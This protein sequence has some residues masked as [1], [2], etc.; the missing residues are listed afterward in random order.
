MFETIFKYPAV[1]VRHR[2]APL[3]KERERYLAH[4]AKDGIAGATL[5]GL[6]RELLIVVREM[7]IESEGMVSLQTIESAA[8]RWARRQKRRHRAKGLGWSRGLF[9]QVARD[10][11]AFL[12]RLEETEPESASFAPLLADFA[13][14]MRCE[15][16]LASATITNYLWFAQ[17]FL[18]WFNE[19]GRLFAEVSVLDVDGFIEQC[20]VNW[21]RV[22]MAGCAKSLRGFF[23]HAQRRGWCAVG[24][25]EA[26]ESPRVFSQ[27]TL[28]A[29]P[30]WH[31]VH[32]LIANSD[33]DRPKDI[34]DRP[35]LMLLSIYGLRSAEVAH[36]RLDDLDWEQERI[37]V[38]RSKQRRTQ[39]F[40]L[41]RNVGEA[42]L[43]YLKQ[44]R[45]RS[46]RREVFLRLRAP[47]VPLSPGGMHNLV[48]TRMVQLNIAS[49]RRGPHSL[50]HAC[51]AHLVAQ[52]FSL[53]EIG[54]H[55]GHRSAYATRV[56]AKV[57][58]DGLREVARFDL[59]GVL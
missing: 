31:D 21:G 11:L 39:E 14:S 22:S 33:T 38:F 4:R 54:D 35:I 10:W 43:R 12:G 24:I 45:P 26:I 47:L 59:D 6:A 36:L 1:V 55:L 25:A 37:R 52:G 53:K 49:S 28:P 50:R 30:D 58:L 34:R 15:R 18:R 19:Q 56:Y 13:R 51:A 44:V 3:A 46:S 32:R 23:R 17:Y 29:G 7:G 57:D 5:V 27:E 40:P 48:S 20:G 41:T 8:E 2:E 42:I 9:V 16:G